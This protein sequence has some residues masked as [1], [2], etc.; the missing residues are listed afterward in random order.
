MLQ[1]NTVAVTQLRG[2]ASMSCVTCQLGDNRFESLQH[3]IKADISAE[4][5]QVIYI[6]R[7]RCQTIEVH[8]HAICRTDN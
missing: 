5:G 7:S 6:R 4:T 8:V 2:G 3:S 1:N